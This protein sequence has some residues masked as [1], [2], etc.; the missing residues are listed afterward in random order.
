MENKSK[1]EFMKLTEFDKRVYYQSQARQLVGVVKNI[2][3]GKELREKNME[4]GMLKSERDEWQHKYEAL[5]RR[6]ENRGKSNDPSGLAKS[7]IELNQVVKTLRSEI[8]TLKRQI[9]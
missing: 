5:V 7:V 9:K 6:N 4:I 3:S 1:Q 2:R 8:S